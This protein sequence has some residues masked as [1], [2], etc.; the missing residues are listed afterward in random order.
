MIAWLGVLLQVALLALA[1]PLLAA[2]VRGLALLRAGEAPGRWDQ[3]V[4]DLVRLWRKAGVVPAGSSLVHGAAPAV[5]VAAAGVAALLVPAFGLGLA[6]GGMADLVVV[7]GLLSLSRAAVALGAQDAG[8]VPVAWAGHAMMRGRLGAEPVMLVAALAV[9]LATGS[10]NLE[11]AA[12][13]LRDGGPGARLGGGLVGL[14]V[15][16]VAAQEADG[17]GLGAWWGRGQGLVVTAGWLRLLTGLSL[18]GLFLWPAGVAAAEAGPGAWVVG[19]LL[20]SLKMAGLAVAVALVPRRGVPQ[21]GV[22]WPGVVA[23][24]WLV[25]MIAAVL[26]GAAGTE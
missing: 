3:P 9:I 8:S 11:I 12:G 2:W 21:R 6:T 23:A 5:A 25:A 18:A 20:W 22:P 15:L 24:A 13:L 17:A 19:V 1:V 10:T 26:L 4:R 14:A 16:G 7:A